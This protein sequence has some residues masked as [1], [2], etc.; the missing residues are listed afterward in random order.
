LRRVALRRIGSARRIEARIEPSSAK[1]S[2]EAC[3]AAAAATGAVAFF[4][5]PA[6]RAPGRPSDFRGIVSSDLQ[7]WS[8]LV[9]EARIVRI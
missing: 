8:T 1:A 3:G 5:A 4:D 9:A 7:R 2:S 6:R